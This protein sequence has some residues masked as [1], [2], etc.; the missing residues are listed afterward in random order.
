VLEGKTVFEFL[1]RRSPG[2]FEK[3]TLQLRPK[4]WQAAEGLAKEVFFA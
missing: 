1:Q 2:E 4:N 3:P